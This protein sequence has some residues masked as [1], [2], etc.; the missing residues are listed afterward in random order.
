MYT[1]IGR[2][3]WCIIKNL[4]L[5]REIVVGYIYATVIDGIVIAATGKSGAEWVSI[6]IK[7]VVGRKYTGKVYLPE[8]GPYTCPGVVI[9]H[10]GMCGG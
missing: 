4:G 8:S 1:S 10:S 7:N 5:Y 6:A 3:K 9:D 2:E